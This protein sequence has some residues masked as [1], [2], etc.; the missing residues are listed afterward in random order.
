MITW[1]IWHLVDQHVRQPRRQ[2]GVHRDP[3]VT[4]ADQA[5]ALASS[6]TRLTSSRARSVSPAAMKRRID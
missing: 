5:S 6:T 3:L 1:R 2:L 4:G